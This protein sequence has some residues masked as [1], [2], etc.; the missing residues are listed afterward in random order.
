MLINL[1]KVH[2]HKDSVAGKRNRPARGDAFMAE[3][4]FGKC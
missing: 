4:L 2:P 3:V 1:L